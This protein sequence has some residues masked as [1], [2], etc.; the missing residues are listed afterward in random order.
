MKTAHIRF[1]PDILRRLGEELN[2]SSDQGILELV[3]NSYDANAMNCRVELVGVDKPGGTVRVVDNGDGMTSDDIASGWLIIGH[4]RKSTRRL[5]RL[6]RIPAGSK[7][8]GRLAALRMGRRASITTRPR[9][10]KSSEYSLDIDWKHFDQAEVVE[11]VELKIQ[12]T[13]RSGPSTPG[14]EIVLSQ[15]HGRMGRMEVKRLARGLVLLADPFVDNPDG[16]RPELAAP[17][18]TDLESLVKKRYFDDAEYHLSAKVQDGLASAEVLDWRGGTLFRA[19]HA[20][21]VPELRKSTHY[22]CPD[23]IFDLWVF[24]LDKETFESR[25]S[26]VGEVREWLGEF[27]GVHLYE[28]GL[29]VMPYGN[30]GNDWLDIN[31][32]RARSP[33]E[34][35][36]TNTSIGRIAVSDRASRLI[37][38]TDRSGFIEEHGFLE[39]RAF[40]QDA[41]E[42]MARRRLD[43]AMKRRSAE[44]Q[45]S[46][47][48]SREAK[49]SL[50]MAV[51]TAPKQAR[52]EIEAAVAQYTGARDKEVRD[53]RKEVQLYR[54]L[55]T[56]GITAATF[57]HE[58]TGNPIK[59]MTVEIR[60]IER[61]TRKL[62]GSLYEK[63]LKGPIDRVSSS[64][65]SLA[66]LSTATLGL[67]DQSKRRLGRVDIHT[68]VRDVLKTFDPFIKVRDV[69]PVPNLADGNPHLRG[70]EA[71]VESIVTNL[72]NNSL[73]A[74]EES[75]TTPRMLSITTAVDRNILTLRVA[76]SGPGI[77]GIDL[78]DIWLPG[79]TTRKNG[80]GLGLT[81]VRDSVLDLGGAVDA[82]AHGKLGGA[83][84]IV[85][86]PI[87]GV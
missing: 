80:T 77:E 23:A 82:M 12:T 31:L 29:R 37:Q 18:F 58:S 30:P 49:K 6:N 67:L 17:E 59:V 54:T 1:A 2:P 69:T 76:D 14:S 9:S 44:R 35:P 5:T 8:L 64:I 7:G 10:E 26:T 38:K 33:E 43:L 28:N 75:N 52:R 20:D 87:I 21:L 62:L 46:R 81:I 47:Q 53:L 83:E 36:S 39:L 41:L 68:V 57:A 11:D 78:K 74:L 73:A 63:E 42:W 55:S 79:Q 85:H 50:E 27:G 48:K 13:H 70:S 72:L 60:T 15:L 34:R 16:F 4:S 32:R 56:A 86:L 66:V 45:E 65:S 51:Q 61:R 25:S 19:T 71:A 84:L 40:A 24:I 22:E 3:K